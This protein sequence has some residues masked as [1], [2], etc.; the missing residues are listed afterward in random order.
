MIFINFTNL[1]LLTISSFLPLIDDKD[2]IFYRK[3]SFQIVKKKTGSKF[4]FIGIL[5]AFIFFSFIIC[6]FP[7][8]FINSQKIYFFRFYKFF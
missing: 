2:S 4:A 5:F 6:L 3:N 1:I 7:N 8:E